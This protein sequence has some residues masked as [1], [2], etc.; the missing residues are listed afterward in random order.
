MHTKAVL[1]ALVCVTAF[2]CQGQASDPDAPNSSR[3]PS[4]LGKWFSRQAPPPPSQP[5]ANLY[6]IVPVA[7]EQAQPKQEGQPKEKQPKD[8]G[9]PAP[10]MVKPPPDVKPPVPEVPPFEF[11]NIFAQQAPPTDVS[12]G[13]N[14]Q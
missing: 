3:A 12:S 2:V 9:K 11:Q 13:F 6:E 1:G 5:L 7:E 4:I 10:D 14:P 8:M